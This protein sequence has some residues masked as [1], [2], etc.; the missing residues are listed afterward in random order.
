MLLTKLKAIIFDMTDF[1]MAN[2]VSRTH[3]TQTQPKHSP[4]LLTAA[5]HQNN[6]TTPP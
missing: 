2:M 4:D 6:R 1:S 3:P 5:P